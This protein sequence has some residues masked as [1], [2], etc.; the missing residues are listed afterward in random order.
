MDE[1]DQSILYACM[2]ISQLNPFDKLIYT[3]KK[4]KGKQNKI[5]AGEDIKKKTEKRLINKVVNKKRDV[6]TTPPKC[7]GS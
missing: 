2:E 5:N 4:R 3:N 1:F 7:K 6:T